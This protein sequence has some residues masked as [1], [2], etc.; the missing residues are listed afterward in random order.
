MKIPLKITSVFIFSLALLFGC[1]SGPTLMPEGYLAE[2]AS[3]QF[4]QM[5][6]EKEVSENP[7]HNEMVRRITER[8]SAV[9]DD[10][11]AV[12]DWEYVVF[13]DDSLNAFAMPGG[14][15]GV[16]TGLIELVDSDDELA[17]VI[18]HEIAHVLLRH[19]NQRMSAEILRG[20]GGIATAYGT[21][22]MDDSDRQM[23]LAA[24]GVGSQVGIML[25]Y[26]RSHETQADREGLILAARAGY[27]PQAAVSFWQKMEEQG[28][29][30][31][32]EFLST[33][34]GYETRIET[35]QEMM[36]EALEVY[37]EAKN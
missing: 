31:P 27:D 21:K 10:D 28:G 24:Y 11:S 6:E 26:S 17:A 9:V 33:H 15:V 2:M 29:S 20:I 7:E 13:E 32:P 8:M 18:G 1:Q 34:P 36:P 22:D 23:I 37:N 25:P 3:A 16:F 30:S 12:E 19:G 4:T 35:L 14:K 5:K